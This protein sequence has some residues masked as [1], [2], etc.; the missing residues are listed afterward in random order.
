MAELKTK[1]HEADV[2]EYIQGLEL[3]EK[4]KTDAQELL[5]LMQDFTGYE[6]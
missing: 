6:P 4:K 2:L 1:Q 3:S 5:K